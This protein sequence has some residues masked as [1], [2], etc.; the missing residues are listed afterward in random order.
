MKPDVSVHLLLGFNSTE[1]EYRAKPLVIAEP[2]GLG[3]VARQNAPLQV[4]HSHHPFK[5]L[6]TLLAFTMHHGDSLA[7]KN[8]DKRMIINGN[9]VIMIAC[10][11]L[12]FSFHFGKRA[13]DASQ[14]KGAYSCSTR[15]SWF[16]PDSSSHSTLRR[17]VVPKDSFY[18][19]VASART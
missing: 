18:G 7:S 12:C 11:Y 4:H 1:A 5:R 15:P 2:Q 13:Q 10:L 19:T 16:L 14:L 3:S 9:I 6:D 17:C 8:G